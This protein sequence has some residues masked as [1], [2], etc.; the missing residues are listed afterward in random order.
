MFSG[1]KYKHSCTLLKFTSFA[2]IPRFIARWRWSYGLKLTINKT[3]FNLN[4]SFTVTKTTYKMN[5]KWAL[6]M[7]ALIRNSYI[8]TCR[9]KLNFIQILKYY[10]HTH[11]NVQKKNKCNG[12]LGGWVNLYYALMQKT[13]YNSVSHIL[14]IT[15]LLKNILWVILVKGNKNITFTEKLLA[16]ARAANLTTQDDVYA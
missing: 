13:P 8:H 6:Q 16:K 7:K 14:D 15:S 11:S 9:I 4:E 2:S 10:L 5:T 12:G 3:P 1:A